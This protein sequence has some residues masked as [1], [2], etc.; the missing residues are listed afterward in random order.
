MK[1]D[2]DPLCDGSKQTPD[3]CLGLFHTC[4]D[5]RS[6]FFSG[7]TVHHFHFFHSFEQIVHSFEFEGLSPSN[8]LAL[9]QMS[10]VGR[11]NI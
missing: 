9:D 11:K 6:V 4:T 1:T 10:H 8:I 5:I 3:T 2:L 7:T